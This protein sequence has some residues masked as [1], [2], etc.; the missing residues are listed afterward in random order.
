VLLRRISPERLRACLALS[1]EKH[2]EGWV[3]SNM[4]SLAQAS[5]DPCL[6]PR[7]VYD[8]DEW[9]NAPDR[10][11]AMK[12]FVMYE[13]KDGAGFIMRLMIDAACQ[14]QGYGRATVM[15]VIRVL[16]RTPEVRVIATSHRNDN[17]A[18]AALY[19]SLGFRPWTSSATGAPGECYLYLD[20]D[21]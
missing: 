3:A 18:A 19:A 15:E 1:V 12:G 4:F 20:V 5:T 16:R 13:L 10:E 2:Q 21:G 8:L 17:A 14:Q 9:M 6:H 11:P 7:A